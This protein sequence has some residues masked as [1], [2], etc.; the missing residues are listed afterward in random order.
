MS[1]GLFFVFWLAAA[2]GILTLHLG[3]PARLRRR[4]EAAAAEFGWEQ[5][6]TSWIFG[7]A[8]GV[9][10]GH[11]VDLVRLRQ[12][13]MTQR[14]RLTIAVKPPGMLRIRFR[15]VFD[16]L[17][18]G[19]PPVVEVPRVEGLQ[20]RSDPPELAA[21]LLDPE[22]IALIGHTLVAAYDEIDLQPNRLRIDC[23]LEPGYFIDQDGIDETLRRA[24]QLGTAIVEVTDR[25]A[26]AQTAT[27]PSHS[28][29]PTRP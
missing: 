14:V 2:A 29:S 23:S 18:F 24:W 13:G 27:A 15:G 25:P 26:P 12:R 10:Q 17:D 20:V 8:E 4:I 6:S 11:R 5:V 1:E 7:G 9:W 28:R 21:S 22:L 16:F 19:G 3:P